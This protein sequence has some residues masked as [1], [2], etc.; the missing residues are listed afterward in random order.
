MAF[1]FGRTTFIGSGA[2]NELE[3]GLPDSWYDGN[4][5]VVGSPVELL[6]V[7]IFVECENG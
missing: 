6:G 3:E 2:A 7:R 4:E 1:F 5:D